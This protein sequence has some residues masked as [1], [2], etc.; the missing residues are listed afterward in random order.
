MSP[1]LDRQVFKNIIARLNEGESSRAIA[2]ALNVSKTSV[3]RARNELAL[4]T[5]EKTGAPRRFSEREEREV[6]NLFRRKEAKTAVQAAKIISE[7]LNK[8]VCAQTVRRCLQKHNFAA[9][10]KIKKPSISEKNRRQRLAWAEKH[11]HW[12]EDDWKRVIWSDESKINRCT[13]DGLAYV[14]T[15]N[16]PGL[17][18]S[19][20]VP[21]LKFGGGSIMVWGCMTWAGVGKI[22]LVEGKMNAQQFT[23]ILERGLIPVLDSSFLIPDFPSFEQLYFQQDNDPKHTSALAREWFKRK[24]IKTMQ[25]PSQSPDLNPIEHLWYHLKCHKLAQ[26][27]EPKGV[28]E[29]W[30]KAQEA[31]NKIDPEYCQ[32]LIKSMPRRI[33]A[34]I[35]A[36]GGPTKY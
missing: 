20:I 7:R 26:V 17:K 14:W 27:Q 12:T 16:T 19:Q 33:E 21:T 3:L 9:R 34:V 22:Q 31:W 28:H 35:K 25:W 24:N 6:I 10:K 15:E 32:S 23:E 8:K 5:P 1:K 11:R 18:N 36:R 30:E 4:E 2:S 13:S 29:L